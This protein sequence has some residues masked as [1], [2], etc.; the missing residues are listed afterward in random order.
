[1]GNEKAF[2]Q[3]ILE[4]LEIHRKNDAHHTKANLIR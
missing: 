4:Q 2:L 3:I 1:M